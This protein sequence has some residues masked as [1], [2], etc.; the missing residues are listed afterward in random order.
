MNPENLNITIP[1]GKD[2]VEVLVREVD[3]VVEQQLP[4]LEPDLVDITGNITAP[5]AFLEKRW[6]ATDGQIDHCRTGI[7]VNRDNLYIELI[8]NETDKRNKK[9]VK[10]IISLSRQFKAF[11]L[12]DKDDWSPEDLGNFIRINKTYF[13]SQK[14]AMDYVSIFKSFKAKVSVSVER[15]QKDNGSMTDSYRQAVD[16]SLPEK[17]I[18][19]I[20]IFK[21]CAPERIVVEVV[22][23][24]NGRDVSLALISSD[25]AGIMEGVRDK[26]IDEQLAKIREFAPEIPIIEV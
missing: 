8:A 22:A 12:N 23:H 21:G 9:H 2:K 13:E 18:I 10:G 20:P 24:V 14:E 11:G 16:S 1:E 19:N 5:F 15:L 6:N 4:V 25:A 17:F 3:K 26:L 7:R